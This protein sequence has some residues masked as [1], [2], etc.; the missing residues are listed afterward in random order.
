MNKKRKLSEANKGKKAPRDIRLK[1][2]RSRGGRPFKN[3]NGEIFEMVK[4]AALKLKIGE[5][6]IYNVL[7]KKRKTTRGYIFTFLNEE[8]E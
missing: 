5:V 1:M 8:P 7:N 4:D 6:G 3:Q 2:S